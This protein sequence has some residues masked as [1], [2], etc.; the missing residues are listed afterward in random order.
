MGDSGQGALLTGQVQA[1]KPGAGISIASDGAISVDSQSVIGLMKLGQTAA[2][3]A[4][5]YN[6]YQWPSATGTVGQQIT[7]SAVAGG[8]TT[9]AWD[10]PDMIP[11]TAKGQLIVGTGANTSTILN[12]GT[13]GQILI[14]DSTT[15][16]GLAYTSNYVSTTGPTGAAN[17]PAGNTG[18]RPATPNDGATRYNSTTTSL[19]FWNGAA[20]ET[21]ASSS[22]NAFV[23]KTSD[24]GSAI[25]PAGTTAQR[26]GAPL[27]GYLRFNDDT[28]L[29]EF[30]NGAS[31]ESIASSTTGSFVAQSVP[32]T[33]TPSAVIPPGSTANRQT[34]PAPVAGYQRFN[35]T[36]NSM[37]FFDGTNWETI[38]SSISGSFIESVAATAPAGA[39]NM[40]AIPGGTTAER[41][42]APL[43]AGYFRYNSSLKCM[44]F[45]DGANWVPIIGASATTTVGLGLAVSGVNSEII[46]VSIT[47]SSVPPTPGTGIA[48]AIDGSMYF[49]SEYG[50]FFYRY[51][52]ASSTSWVQALGSDTDGGALDFPAG[53]A[54]GDTYAAPNG[55][56]YTFDGTKG[57][58]TQGAGGGGG[59]TAA[60][61]AEAAAG[62]LN[63]KY[64]SPETAVPK[65]ASGMTGA[66]ILPGGTSAQQPGGAAAG[67]TRYN[68][69]NKGLEFYD[70]T[71]WLPVVASGGTAGGVNLNVATAAPATKSNGLGLGDGDLYANTTTDQ[72]FSRNT[73]VWVPFD[74]RNV[75]VVGADYQAFA[76]DYVVVTTS[77]LTI[78]L[79]ATP[80]AGTVVTVVVAGTFLDTV[81]ARN[82]EN[83][84][85]LAQDITLDSAYN[86]VQF[87]YTDA[88]NGWRIN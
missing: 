3:A 58:W 37:E 65:N 55:V 79:P 73:G 71:N 8:V 53:P 35:S 24:T 11:W 9:L 25:M 30:W 27:G 63:T 36:T 48:Q 67:W 45:Y 38:A 87:T 60:T 54:A 80:I 31:W 33:G 88:T 61:L 52:G 76:N 32:T 41:A 7:I 15:A 28:D 17:M 40:A 75:K 86:A 82:G 13:N 26:N 19:E 56:T 6:S 62:T 72:Y 77:G 57:V 85:S 64:S 16:S 22:S 50:S 68:S 10:D 59:V 49:D 2:T 78:T 44:E 83:I 29:M 1:V 5:A 14:A 74:Q 43:V 12:V 34:A 18:A 70:G 66:A 69:T 46:K 51:V 39:T 84:M 23:E 47:G 4:S 20:W 42:T 81:V 21:V